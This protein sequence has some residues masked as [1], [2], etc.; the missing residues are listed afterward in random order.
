M[1][2]YMCMQLY[3]HPSLLQ[4]QVFE[5]LVSTFVTEVELTVY[6]EAFPNSGVGPFS[7][8]ARP[9]PFG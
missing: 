2:V 9:T 6:R 8:E 4:S 7:N 1:P 5:G 3:F